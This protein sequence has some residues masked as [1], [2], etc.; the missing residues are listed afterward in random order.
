M[1]DEG[2]RLPV[3][4]SAGIDVNEIR[5]GVEADTPQL[6]RS[7]GASKVIELDARQPDVDRLAVHVQAARRHASNGSPARSKLRVGVRRPIPRDDVKGPVGLE[8]AAK[9]VQQVEQFRVDGL[10]LVDTEIPQDVIDRFERIRLIDTAAA[11]RRPEPLARVRVEERKHTFGEGSAGDGSRGRLD[12]A[13]QRSRR[14]RRGTDPEETPAVQ[15]SIDT[16][17]LIHSTVILHPGSRSV[18]DETAAQS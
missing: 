5:R 14:S 7:C 12:A 2:R 15:L 9:L 10:H 17:V 4:H 8:R 6:Q 11:I 18:V 1:K 3:P 13:W 16:H